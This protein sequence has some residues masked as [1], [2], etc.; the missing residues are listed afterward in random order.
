MLLVVPGCF[1]RP[2]LIILHAGSLSVP[3]DR[4]AEAFEELNPGVT[5]ETESAGSRT[6]IRKVTELGKLADVV[7]SADY[8]AI[9]E[10]MFP[11]YADWYISFATN[12]MVIAYTGQSQYQEEITADN[13]YE[14][15]LR[16][17]VNYGHSDPDADPCGY[18]SLMLWQLAEEYYGVPGLY[19]S[20]DEGCPPENIRPKETDL[21]ALL[22]SG[23]MDYAFEYRSVAVQRGL[24]Y[25]SLPDEIDLSNFDLA[26]LYSQAE[27]EVTGAEP[28]T[29]VTLLSM[30]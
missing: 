23:D 16:E 2:S 20:L 18:R 17:G 21:I 5:V 24:E 14:V 19:E 9:E 7:A 11:E 6:T 26:D 22:Q 28:G 1:P 10:L 12:E 8:L 15:L 27:V 29:T 13:W 25:L 4:V 3:F 30:G